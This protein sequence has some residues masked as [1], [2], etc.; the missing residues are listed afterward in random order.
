MIAGRGGDDTPP[1]L[2]RAQL[3]DQVHA[4]ADL[5]GADGLMVLV[6]DPQMSPCHGI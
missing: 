5:E 4:T 6:L 1:P 3:A 2:I